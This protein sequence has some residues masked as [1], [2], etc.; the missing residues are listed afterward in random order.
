MTFPSSI[1]TSRSV[2]ENLSGMR[3]DKWLQL[4]FPQH[5][6]SELQKWVRD[7]RITCGD[8][9]L[10]PGLK[11]K[12][13]MRFEFS[14][15]DLPDRP[16]LPEAENLPL[17]ILFEDAH[18]VVVN[19]FAGQ[20]VHPAPGHAGGT[21]LNAMLH[22][23]PDMRSAGDPARPGLVHRLDIETSGLL[24][25]ARTPDALSALQD[26]FKQRTVSKTYHC[27]CHSIPHPISQRMD[28]PIGRHPVHRKKRAVNGEGARPAVS[29]LHVIN[30]LAS[31]TAAFLEV[32][33]ETGRTH[34]IRVHLAHIGHPVLG[35][36]TYGG[37]RAHPPPPWPRAPRIMLHARHLRIRHPQ[38]GDLLELE[39]P[40][41]D[42][43]S[44]YLSHLQ[45]PSP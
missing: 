42:D 3:L 14:P 18:L 38:T 30:G 43:M 36:T 9:R 41:P 40:Y 33:I 37:K 39:A 19:K 10:T 2:S 26:Q 20:V 17:D 32:N 31:G 1:V 27:I 25:F 11:V 6:R 23:C 45:H 13:G 7:G 15:P 29:R 35:D 12:T 5:S 34:Q 24:V 21:V 4:E 16:S 8:T 44:T 22:H 28:A